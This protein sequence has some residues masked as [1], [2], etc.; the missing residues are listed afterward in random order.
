M[1]KRM[2]RSIN[3]ATHIVNTMKRAVIDATASAMRQLDI[4]ARYEHADPTEII[5]L[6]IVQSS[7]RIIENKV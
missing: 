2:I 6:N 1:R 5:A 4:L 7:Q 3:K